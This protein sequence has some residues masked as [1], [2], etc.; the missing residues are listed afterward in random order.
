MKQRALTAALCILGTTGASGCYQKVIRVKAGDRTTEV[1]EPDFNEKT[2]ELDEVMWGPV[3]KGK[4]PETYYRKKK[5]LLA[6]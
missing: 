4:D 1:A 5:Q 2:T 3:P 6:E